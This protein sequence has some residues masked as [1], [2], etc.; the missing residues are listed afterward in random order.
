MTYGIY[1]TFRS[2]FWR[3]YKVGYLHKNKDDLQV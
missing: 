1:N 2:L 3:I